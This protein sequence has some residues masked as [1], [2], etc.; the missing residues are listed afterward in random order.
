MSKLLLLLGLLAGIVFA[1]ANFAAPAIAAEP[2]DTTLDLTLA[3]GTRAIFTFHASPNAGATFECSLD[4]DD[5]TACQRFV[6]YDGIS[7]G[8]HTFK[9]R[10]SAGGVVDPTP[11]TYTWVVDSTTPDTTITQSP[12]S[13]S[14]SISATF[15]FTST[16]ENSTFRCKLDTG[17]ALPCVS[18]RTY[19]ALANGEHT[20]TVYAVDKA[21]NK[22]E[23][24]ASRTFTVDAKGPDVTITAHPDATTSSR[25]A[26][27][28]FES[29]AANVT[30]RC[31]LDSRPLLPCRSPKSYLRLQPGQHTFTVYAVDRAG[32]EDETPA[33]FTWT[34]DTSTPD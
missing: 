5:F 8:E 22:D 21:G 19:N 30:F 2:P 13:P 29:K 28:S 20:F 4:D 26:S 31:Q 1:Q 17:P 18:P 32:N 3:F 6:S 24:P 16:E 33:S 9:V 25:N 7:G 10:A 11:A 15:E 14:T 23:T 27:F 34:I 12:E